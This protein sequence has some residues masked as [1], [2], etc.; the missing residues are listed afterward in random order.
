MDAIH[1]PLNYC[2]IA[3]WEVADSFQA[4]KYIGIIGKFM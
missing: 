3:I 1:S 2:T 4:G